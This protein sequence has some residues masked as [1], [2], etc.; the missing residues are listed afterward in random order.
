MISVTNENPKKWQTMIELGNSP[1]GLVGAPAG[2]IRSHYCMPM[3]PCRSA[4]SSKIGS[5]EASLSCRRE[6][7]VNVSLLSC[8]IGYLVVA[9][10][11]SL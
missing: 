10:G 2:R 5:D 8:S 3:Y 6:E 11:H 7:T 1:S 4:R 9:L